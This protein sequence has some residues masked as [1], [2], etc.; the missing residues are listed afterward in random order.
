MARS[1]RPVFTFPELDSRG[2]RTILRSAQEVSSELKAL[3][4]QAMEADEEG[5]DRVK[6][7]YR[8]RPEAVEAVEDIRRIL[9]RQHGVRKVN[10]E[11]IAQAAVMEALRQLEESG[12]ESFVVKRFA[13]RERP[14]GRSA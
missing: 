3:E 5:K 14:A 11:D 13:G 4:R 8:F 6:V 9:R 12:A 10:R 7:T 1:K 2:R